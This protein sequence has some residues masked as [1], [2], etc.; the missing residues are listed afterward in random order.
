LN[1]FSGPDPKVA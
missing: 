1:F